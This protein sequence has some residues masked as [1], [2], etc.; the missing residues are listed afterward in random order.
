M[1][2]VTDFEISD[3]Q[4]EFAALLYSFQGAPAHASMAEIKQRLKHPDHE[5]AWADSAV[6]ALLR[7]GFLGVSSPDFEQP[8][9]SYATGLNIRRLTLAAGQPNAQLVIHPAFRQALDV[10]P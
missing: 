2:L 9:Y 10:T 1:L 6:E 8:L 3:T 7:F 5:P 4:P